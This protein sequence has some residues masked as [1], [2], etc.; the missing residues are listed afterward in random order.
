[1]PAEPA[2][3]NEERISYAEFGA[4]FFEH[5]VSKERVLSA[6]SGLAGDP[7]NFGPIGV[8]PGRLAQVKANGQVGQPSAVRLQ[9]EEVAFLLSIP[10]E[11]DLQIYLLGEKHSFHAS[12][13]VTLTLT[14]RAARP[15]CIVIDINE[16]RTRDVVVSIEADGLRATVLRYVGGID[17]EIARFVAKYVGREIDKPRIQAARLIDVAAR[18]DQAWAG[19]RERDK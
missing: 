4:G 16:P 18:I 8:G 19:P 14:A 12:I 13:G 3:N 7:I 6:L 17:R 15:L 10:V 2:V 1:M 9:G 11:L 5:A